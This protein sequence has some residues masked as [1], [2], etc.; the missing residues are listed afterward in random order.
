M[1]DPM[2][3][4]FASRTMWVLWLTLITMV[5]EIVCGIW[6]GSMALTADGWHMGSHAGAMFVAWLTYRLTQSKRMNQKLTFGAGKMIAL[7]GFTS[8][9]ALGAV[10]VGVL[11]ESTLRLFQSPTIQFDEAIGVAVAGL[12]VNLV[13][14]KLLHH[15]HHH[16][17]DHDESDG[18]DHHH[19][20][21][22][23]IRSAYFHVLADA[24]TSV[25]A[26]AALL[27]GKYYG[28]N[29]LDAAVGVLGGFVILNWSYGLIKDSGAELLDARMGLETEEK[30]RKAVEGA[31][32]QAIDLHVW[33][34]GPRRLAAEVVIQ[35]SQ[36]RGA[37][38]YRVAILKAVAVN[39]LVVEERLVPNA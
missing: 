4:H 14:A 9:I 10:A 39:H 34:L 32:S 20:S 38:H 12:I 24:L 31:G 21:D 1:D 30:L 6:F 8:A 15:E 17:H 22:N 11:I 5:A 26:I 27:C 2:V 36:L 16:D 29:F 37:E 3:S 18:H 33:R 13:S 7:G 23:N 25:L 19:H 28:W 35:T